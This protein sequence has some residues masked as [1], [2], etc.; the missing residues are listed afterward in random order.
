MNVKIRHEIDFENGLISINNI[1][2]KADSPIIDIKG[3]FPG[4]LTRP[5]LSLNPRQ[6][7][8]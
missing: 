2:A 7:I 5:L 4:F 8:V 6:K 3:Y 1:D